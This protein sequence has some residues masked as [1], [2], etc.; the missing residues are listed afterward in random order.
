MKLLYSQFSRCIQSIFSSRIASG[1][2]DY[3][4]QA[5]T[6]MR[7]FVRE[8]K[9]QA[10]PHT[11][12]SKSSPIPTA[13]WCCLVG[14]T[15]LLAP[16]CATTKDLDTLRAQLNDQVAAVQSDATQSRQAIDALK[17]DVMLL[18]SLGIAVDSLKSRVDAAQVRPPGAENR[19]RLSP[20]N[21]RQ[22]AG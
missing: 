10:I 8:R 7:E 4:L 9:E 16:G 13:I 15:V 18:K 5:Q 17:T 20:D 11:H 22:Y 3:L 1:S 14:L 12:P 6:S 19:K 2:S 21:P